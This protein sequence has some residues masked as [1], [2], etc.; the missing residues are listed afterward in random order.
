MVGAL[1]L[2]LLWPAAVQ[3]QEDPG[4]LLLRDPSSVTYTT[5]SL[6][7]R[8]DLTVMEDQPNRGSFI[9]GALV[10][11]GAAI[12]VQEIV[13]ARQRSRDHSVVRTVFKHRIY[14]PVA[15]TSGMIAFYAGWG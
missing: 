13:I 8:A 3:A 4:A 11:L 10:G 1:V 6:T 5:A 9:K 2:G 14:L 15:I 12:L 7:V